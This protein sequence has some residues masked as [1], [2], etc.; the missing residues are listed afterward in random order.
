MTGLRYAVVFRVNEEVLRFQPLAPRAGTR[1]RIQCEQLVAVRPARLPETVHDLQ[2]DQLAVLPSGGHPLD[3]LHDGNDGAK[4]SEYLHVLFVERLTVVLVGIVL[5]ISR[6]PRPANDGIG[7]AWRSPRSTVLPPCSSR[8]ASIRRRR[9][10][11][12]PRLPSS[13]HLVSSHAAA[14]SFGWSPPQ[15]GSSV[16][17]PFRKS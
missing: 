3:V 8:I 2:K 15:S 14:H 11:L 9:K 7:L 17:A 12:A 5:V 6:V 1:A 16:I 10:A 4:S 13:M